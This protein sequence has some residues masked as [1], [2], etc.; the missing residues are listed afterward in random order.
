MVRP[1]RPTARLAPSVMVVGGAALL[2]LLASCSMC[3]AQ[4]AASVVSP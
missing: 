1:A 4:Q 2:I 3:L